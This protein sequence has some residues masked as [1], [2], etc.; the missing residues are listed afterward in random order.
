MG[1]IQVGIPEIEN[2]GI[3]LGTIEKN[4]KPNMG[5]DDV[6]VSLWEKIAYGGGDTACNISL[7]VVNSLLTLFY[8]DYA[9]I[10]VGIVGMVMLLS[11]V[12]DGFSDVAMGFITEKV[13]SKWGKARPWVLWT[14][15]PYFLST[16]ALFFVPADASE[17]V[18]FIYIFV[19]Y[20]LVTTVIY[21][22]LN[23]P[24][25]VLGSLMTR[26]QHE[27][28][29]IAMV[30]MGMS[31]LGKI[32]AVTFTLP[33]VKYF[34]N[35]QA[36]WIKAISMWSAVAFVL[37]IICFVFC[38][39]RVK[40]SSNRK[41]KPDFKKG[42]KALFKN[43]YWAYCLML[44]A[45]I[46]IHNTIVGMNLPYYAKYILGNDDW[47]YSVLYTTE[48]LILGLGSFCCSLLLRKVSKRDMALGGAILAIVAQLAFFINPYSFN[49]AL[50]TIAI[51]SIGEAPMFAVIFGML[52]DTVEYGQWKTHTRY[53]GLIFS[54]S[55][56]GS[57]V[58][59]GL[60]NALIGGLLA[61]SGYI[62]ST[63]GSLVK[64]PESAKAMILTLYKWGPVV[65]WVLIAL[66][67]VNY[68]LDK[69]YP[70]IMVELKA[71]EAR[72]EL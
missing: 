8:T 50:I 54:S 66:I 30:R 16:V 57:K 47:M 62:S 72:G 10:S 40:I 5:N 51:R 70:E 43:K 20:N 34:G 28:G 60:M 11:R 3:G 48:F 61:F 4:I 23:L 27:R 42:V 71:R 41:E 22:A 58:G 2:S 69:I 65:S 45:L 46:N 55:S 68:K 67:L 31:P 14:A 24:Y 39:E 7:G 17:M 13:N 1:N 44:W 19:T 36:A 35:D 59:P 38:K 37:L 63:A 15:L 26:N 12:F 64:Q 25:S 56:L 52:A 49:W 53:E 33:I 21:T 18:Q 9:G 29:V 6:K 32:L